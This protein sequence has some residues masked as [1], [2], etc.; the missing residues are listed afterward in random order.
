M[1]PVITFRNGNDN[2]FF[3]S[4]FVNI[5]EKTSDLINEG[6]KT[7][8]E[9]I[10]PTTWEKTL[11]RGEEVLFLLNHQ[12]DRVLGSTSSG[13]KLYETDIG[14]K[15]EAEIHDETLVQ[16]VKKNRSYLSG[17]SFGFI[18]KAA[19]WSREGEYN[20]RKISDL[21]L[22]EVSLLTGNTRPAYPSAT[23]IEVRSDGMLERRYI[24][25]ELNMNGSNDL[26]YY[27][28]QINYL[29]LKG[30]RF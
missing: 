29:T 17:F 20:I 11:A 14:L 22:L 8:R 4:G 12:E 7:F 15:I 27:Q 16:K 28:K 19:K 18:E 24:D 25:F 23:A 13:V 21:L 10:L 2:S 3:L 9:V 5:T 26:S 30:C 1:I 6:G